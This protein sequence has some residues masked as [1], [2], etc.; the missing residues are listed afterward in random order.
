MTIQEFI[1]KAIEGGYEEGRN[2]KFVRANRYWVQ[3][4]DSNGSE[5]SINLNCYLLAPEVWKAVGR[6]EG[7]I[8]PDGRDVAKYYNNDPKR[9]PYPLWLWKMHRMV[10]ALA[11]GKTV[12]FYFKN[13]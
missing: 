13:L 3:W 5:V 8:Y 1:E 7:W 9:T 11:D 10:D 2:W 6:A 4:L 12:E